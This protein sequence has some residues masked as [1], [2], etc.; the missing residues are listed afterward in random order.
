MGVS[1]FTSEEEYQKVISS[2]DVVVIDF[3]ATWCG[4]CR[5]VSPLFEKHSDDPKFS[6]VKFY[7]VDVDDWP[8]ISSSAGVRAMPTFM[9]F[10]AGE[11]IA[12]L[13][14]A[15]PTKLEELLSTAAKSIAPA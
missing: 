8:G 4:P 3:T 12:D 11:R 5:I 15:I 14:G 9:V 7:Q 1:T 6:G 13:V 10:Q 2:G